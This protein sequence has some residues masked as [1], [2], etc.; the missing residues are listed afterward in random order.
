MKDEFYY[1][2]WNLFNHVDEIAT[3]GRDSIHF[4]LDGRWKIVH[5]SGQVDYI[6]AASDLCAWLNRGEY[7]PTGQK[8]LR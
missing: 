5:A 2:L 7:K 3:N 8:V 1:S 4:S 6:D